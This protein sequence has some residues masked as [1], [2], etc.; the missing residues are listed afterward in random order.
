MKFLAISGSH[1]KDGNSYFLSKAVLDSLDCEYEIIQLAEKDISFCTVCEECID[2]DCVLVD[3]LYKIIG[4]MEEAD[5]LIFA[6]PK[7]LSAP[8]KFTAFLERLASMA[9]MRKHLSYAG[10][11]VNPDYVLFDGAK[12]FCVFALSGR[13][14]FSEDAL[15]TIVEYLEDIGLRLVSHE[16]PPFVAVN[17][18]AGDLVGEV[19]ENVEAVE[20]CRGLAHKLVESVS[21]R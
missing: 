15:R 17:V 9:H 20:A 19:L 8:S 14:E 6:V 21:I 11:P 16:E 4:K 12:P 7:Y 5:A 1:R 13:G 10:P 18:V 3:D 2:K